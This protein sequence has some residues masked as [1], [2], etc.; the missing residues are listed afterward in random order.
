LKI[1]SLAVNA[2]GGISFGAFRFPKATVIICAGFLEALVGKI[3][4]YP[5]EIVIG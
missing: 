4:T 2:W 3:W 1:H 5:K